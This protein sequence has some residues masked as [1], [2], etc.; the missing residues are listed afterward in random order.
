MKRTGHTPQQIVEKLSEADR[1]LNVGQTLGPVLQALA[2][3]EA[4]CHRWRNH[5]GG[6]QADA[7]SAVAIMGFHTRGPASR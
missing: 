7:A 1:L 2:V 6:M 5:Y 4:T 3:S